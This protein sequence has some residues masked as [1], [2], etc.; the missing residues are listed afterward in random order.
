[1]AD[2]ESYMII[3]QELWAECR[4]A[5]KKYDNETSHGQHVI[6]NNRW[7]ENISDQLNSL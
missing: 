5:Q 2:F 6:E 7:I 4:V 3:Y 1:M